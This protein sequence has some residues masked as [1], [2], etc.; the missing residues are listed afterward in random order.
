MCHTILQNCN[1]IERLKLIITLRAL[2]TRAKQ[3]HVNFRT[4]P[5]EKSVTHA[6]SLGY[7]NGSTCLYTNWL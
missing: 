2:L 1:Q 5:E 3:F 6:I 4:W 7:G